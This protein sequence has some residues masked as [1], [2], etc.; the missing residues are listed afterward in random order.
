LES[1]SAALVDA[2]IIPAEP[3]KSDEPGITN[4]GLG[5]MGDV[6]WLNQRSRDVGM[7]KEKELRS[8]AEQMII[9]A[10]QVKDTV[11]GNDT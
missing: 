10:K 3:P 11:M 4:G 7:D 5:N 1:Q 2:G 8:E 6:A 9:D